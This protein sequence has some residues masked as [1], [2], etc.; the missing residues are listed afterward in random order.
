MTSRPAWACPGVS[1]LNARDAPLILVVEDNPANLRLTAALLARAGYRMLAAGS[2]AQA[3]E[4]LAEV[5]PDLVLLDLGL[6]D[7]DGL[8]L[9]PRL[10]A[11]IPVLAVTAYA[12]A[13]DRG[14][15][16]AAGCAGFLTKPLDT[17]SFTDE[18]AAAVARRGKDAEGGEALGPGA[19]G[20]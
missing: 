11:G 1:P 4:R 17:R 13:G 14:R 12:M 2:L 9:L 16:L 19:A 20:G 6:P 10:G 3:S 15:A 5:R 18:V 7:G 8:E